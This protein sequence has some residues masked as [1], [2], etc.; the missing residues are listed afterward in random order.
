MWDRSDAS[1][2]SGFICLRLSICLHLSSEE[3][4]DEEL[5]ALRT[6]QGEDPKE[7]TRAILYSHTREQMYSDCQQSHTLFFPLGALVD[8]CKNT[9]TRAQVSLC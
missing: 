6:L 4:C 9:C 2:C 8:T 1:V 3:L 5:T 7:M